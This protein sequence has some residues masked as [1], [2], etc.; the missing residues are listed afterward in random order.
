MAVLTIDEI[1]VGDSHIEEIKLTAEW[2]SRFIDL[3]QDTAGIHTSETFSRRRGFDDLVV[4]GF[5][6]SVQFSR[7]LGMHLP[8]EASVIGSLELNFL[9]PVYVGDNVRYTATVTRVL[10]PLGT[11]L[12]ELH[13]EK[14]D[15]SRCVEGKTTC[16]FET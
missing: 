5:L 1:K 8:G 7:I 12:L 9:Q 11:V 13:I 3:T 4:H 15:G 2:V 14:P 16:V 10:R 6:L